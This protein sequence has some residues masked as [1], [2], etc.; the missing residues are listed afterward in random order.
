MSDKARVQWK[1][2]V[3]S[4]T[5]SENVNSDEKEEEEEEEEVEV[6]K[7][8]EKEIKEELKHDIVLTPKEKSKARIR[9]KE[10]TKDM[11]K[12]SRRVQRRETIVTSS[13]FL[14]KKNLAYYDRDIY[15]I[16]KLR[17]DTAVI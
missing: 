6:K 1:A 5:V 3:S 9:F 7:D 11:I 15:D 2:L 12:V 16:L 10:I 13:K 8:F 4:A 14:K 17:K